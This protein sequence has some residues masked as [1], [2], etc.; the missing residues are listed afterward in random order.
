MNNYK[1]YMR[2]TSYRLQ[3]FLEIFDHLTYYG[4]AKT[5][6][7]RWRTFLSCSHIWCIHLIM[8]VTCKIIK[9]KIPNSK[10]PVICVTYR[11]NENI[12]Y[13]FEIYIYMDVYMCMYSYT[14]VN[15]H[16]YAH[17]LTYNHLILISVFYF[18]N[19]KILLKQMDA[20]QFDYVFTKESFVGKWDREQISLMKA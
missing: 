8:L 3:V 15:M 4:L 10:C 14:C 9:R 2:I 18:L 16:I 6:I 11:R 19:V 12:M 20:V 13:L 5:M 7:Q 17:K 1:V